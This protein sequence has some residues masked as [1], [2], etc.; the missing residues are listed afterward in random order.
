MN[1]ENVITQSQSTN[2]IW[3][4]LI[5]YANQI[6]ANGSDDIWSN[7]TDFISVY[8]QGQ[9]LLKSDVLSIPVINVYQDF[10]NR[11]EDIKEEWLGKDPTMII[12]EL[13]ALEEP[14]KF[15]YDVF[16]GLQNLY[17]GAHPLVVELPSS[18]SWLQWLHRYVQPDQP[19]T[20]EE[21]DIEFV[22][23]YLADYLQDFSTLKISGLVI[24][25]HEPI[26]E[27]S[28][29]L[30]LYQPVLNVVKHFQWVAGIDPG[31]K[32]SS[33]DD[34]NDKVEFVL[35]EDS[36]IPE[37]KPYWEN[38]EK[39]GGGL[40]RDFWINAE[41]EVKLPSKGLAYGTIPPESNPEQVLTQLKLLRG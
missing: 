23:M 35:Y 1:L 41:G 25:E 7:T 14:K 19:V 37:M 12:G 21:D 36:S 2:K 33:T 38:E 28:E 5:H 16:E 40:N 27:P 6:F 11:R 3:I 32:T 15:L 18:Q 34:I 4:N 22:S 39:V 9:G 29:I 30:P 24:K 26:L 31:N 13:L 20:I 17:M 8:S 10:I